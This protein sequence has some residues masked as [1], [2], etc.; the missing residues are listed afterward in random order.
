MWTN[1]AGN[2]TAP[3]RPETPRT[4]EEL[5]GLIAGGQMIRPVGAGHSFTPLI[6]GAGTIVD[7]S[8][9]TGDPVISVNGSRARVRAG[10][11]LYELAE[12]LGAHGFAFRNLGDINVQSLAG[13]MST[14]TH[15]T[16]A[17]LPCLAAEMTGAQ[18]LTASGE[19]LE[20]GPDEMPGAR[21]ALGALGVLTEI[22]FNV[23]PAYDLR[24]RVGVAPV[25]ILLDEMHDLWAAHRHFE[26]FWIP[27]TGKG[28]R[29]TH[30]VSTGARGRAPMD[31]DNIA[32]KVFALARNLG[33]VS[34]AARR[35]L[36]KAVLAFQSDE[37]FTG[38]SWQVL[39]KPRAVKFVEMEYH[40]PPENAREALLE[41]IRLTE[42]RHPEIY[43]PVEVRQT[44]GDDGWLSPFQ[45]GNRVSVAVHHDARQDPTA[46]F[47]DAEAIFRAAGGRPHWGKMHNLVRRDLEDLYPGLP[48]FDALRKRLDP[49]GRFLSPALRRLLLP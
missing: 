48:K 15:G 41:I 28:L 35:A 21:V 18:I 7:L 4:I 30:E 3:G 46:Y 38:E 1:W 34:P 19:L 25:E 16:G 6:G 44:A 24:R 14:A 5:R 42:E 27:H 11:R 31:L 20:L 36:M 9:M 12:A 22:E 33:R 8:Q 43:F 37:D 45:G 49:E 32:L 23:V 47:R 2:E 17:T 26:F 40:L 10:A 13:A 29:V 39:S